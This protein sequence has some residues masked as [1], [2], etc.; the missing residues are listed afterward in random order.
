MRVLIVGS[1]G[2]IGGHLASYLADRVELFTAD[3]V[4]EPSK[5]HRLLPSVAADMGSLIGELLPDVCVNCSGAANVG[6]SFRD[7]H[8]DFQLNTGLVHD[9]L[10]AIRTRSPATRLLNLSSAAVYG[11]P[12]GIPIDEEAV[13][14]PISPYGWHKLMAENL[15]REYS[16]CFDVQTISLR[17]FSV[18]GPGLRKQLFWD[19]FQKSRSSDTIVCPGT[20]DETRDFISVLDTVQAI[21]LCIEK[22]RFDGQVVNV[23]NGQGITIRHAIETLLSALEWSGDLAFSGVV[24]EGDPL[25]WTAD[26]SCLNALGYSPAVPFET[27]ISELAKWLVNLP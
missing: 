14:K 11:N 16:R 24:R 27:G 13:P 12:Q 10:E 22:A 19:I 18:F 17:P 26:I 6:L 7:P 25:Y 4:G 20:G 21:S 5:R 2:F 9:L 8:L 23:A 3:I 15:C 1:G